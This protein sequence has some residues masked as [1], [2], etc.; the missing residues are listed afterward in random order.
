[1]VCKSW[2]R[3]R[4]RLADEGG[5]VAIV[6]AALLL[7]GVGLAALAVDAG[8]LYLERRRDQGAVDLAAIVAAQDMDRAEAA[9]LAMLRANGYA[10]AVDLEVIRGHY[11]AGLSVAPERR[12][13]PGA[14]PFNAV[15]LKLKRTG[16]SY[17]TAAALAGPAE[18]GV[19]A[20]GLKAAQATFSVGSRLAGA[21]DG[22]ANALLTALLG[23]SVSLSAGDY[24]ALL[25]SQVTL[26]RL[27]NGLAVQ[28]N[29]KAKTYADV[30][31]ASASVGDVLAV[32]AA[33]A[34][35]QGDSGAEAALS[36]LLSHTSARSIKVRL[37]HVIKLGSWGSVG[38]G[39][40]TP[41]LDAAV[42]ALGLITGA[43]VVANGTRQ[44]SF[45]L[46]SMPGV[47]EVRI[48]VAIGEPLSHSGWVSVGE[49]GSVLRTSQI[50]LR[51]V[52]QIGGSGLLAG[53][54]IRLP[55]AVNAT[56]AT[57]RLASIDCTAGGSSAV[58]G[59]T[60]GV[61]EAWIGETAEPYAWGQPVGVASADLVRTS[62]ISVKGAGDVVAGNLSEATL[63]FDQTDVDAGTVKSTDSSQID[64]GLV[65]TL[66]SQSK[67]TVQAGG[68]GLTSPAAVQS[69]VEH[70]LM[71][72]A[73][74]LDAVVHT[75]LDTLG[76]H[77]GEADVRVYGIRCS[78]AVLGR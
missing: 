33:V 46:G 55:I 20:L 29:A 63:E 58:V 7:A 70:A 78:G 77:L 6:T 28:L 40:G 45:D 11:I 54:T 17:F 21:H 36:A 26:G 35:Q 60:P 74:P 71:T 31:R 68:L 37:D 30:L 24:D 44:V 10:G 41:G 15:K 61:A 12:F 2:K 76:V 49:A 64:A 38:V 16:R 62:L 23:G 22:I 9:A 39:Q 52:A 13:T 59:V 4:A 42:G 5:N 72:A 43:A 48:D 57:A 8:S 67:L 50:K 51:L 18:T 66:V 25:S 53:T 3:A 73:A 32:L 56:H 47:G 34:G 14:E 65:S 1:M 19:T 27:L 75:L 69:A